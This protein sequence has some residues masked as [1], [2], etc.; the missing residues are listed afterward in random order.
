M[1]GACVVRSSY[2]VV[3]D[4]AARTHA[5]RVV[6]LR[7]LAHEIYSDAWRVIERIWAM[8]CWAEY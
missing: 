2:D 7:D 6:Y 1:E 3:S 4:A 8:L 5:M